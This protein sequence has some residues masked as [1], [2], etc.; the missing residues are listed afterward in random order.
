MDAKHV[1]LRAIICKDVTIDLNIGLPSIKHFDLLP[2]LTSHISNTPCCEICD[3][4]RS[5][6]TVISPVAEPTISAS[7]STLRTTTHSNYPT[8][9]D[10]LFCHMEVTG[11]YYTHPYLYFRQWHNADNSAQLHLSDILRWRWWRLL[12]ERAYPWSIINRLWHRR[13]TIFAP[14]NSTHEY[15]EIFSYS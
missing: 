2:I 14:K 5:V 9:L 6:A 15:R 12:N 7:T 1:F 13:I 3:V 4:L 8:D 10:T 11:G